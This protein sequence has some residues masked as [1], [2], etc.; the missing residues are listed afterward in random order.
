MRTP[1]TIAKLRE[2]RRLIRLGATSRDIRDKLG[3]RFPDIVA[4]RRLMRLVK[5]HHRMEAIDAYAPRL[6]CG[7]NRGA[8]ESM[9]DLVDIFNSPPSRRDYG[10]AHGRD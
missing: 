7:S 5:D 6:T 2:A 8:T 4:Q 9:G 1:E 10:A 3:L